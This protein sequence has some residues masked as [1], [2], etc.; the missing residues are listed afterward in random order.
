MMDKAYIES[1]RLLLESAPAIFETPH[2]AMKGGTALNLFMADLPRLSVDIDV[3]YTHHQATRDEA[4]K[5]IASGLEAGRKRLAK[6]GL[7]AEVSATPEGDEIKLF[8]RRGRQ[9]AKVE[10][11]HVFRGTVLPVATRRLGAAA[12]KL[13]TTELSVPVLAVPELYGSKLVAAMDRQ[14][15]RDLFDVHGLFKRGGLTPEVVE[16]FVCYLAGH[17][18]PV[19]EVLYSRDTDM[20]SAFDNEFAGMTRTPVTLPELQRVRRQLK[21][22]LPAALTPAQRQFL[23]GLVSGA[24]D[25]SLMKCRHLAQLPAIKWKIQNLAKLKQSNPGKFTQQS[26]ELRVRLGS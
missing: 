8:L 6:I 1:V 2:F 5:A 23:L 15:P 18:R 4:L 12:R 19:H 21:L 16:C 14:H 17:N 7:E 10:V 24:P 26:E 25:W 3:V 13:F 22:E 20:S 9:Q 11:N